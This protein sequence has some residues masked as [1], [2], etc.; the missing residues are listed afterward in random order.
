M[1]ISVLTIFQEEKRDVDPDVVKYSLCFPLDM[2]DRKTFCID[3]RWYE[4]ECICPLDISLPRKVPD[5]SI[6]I[7]GLNGSYESPVVNAKFVMI[8]GG[9]YYLFYVHRYFGL[10]DGLVCSVLDKRKRRFISSAFASSWLA[11]FQGDDS[12]RCQ[13]S[14]YKGSA[15][16]RQVYIVGARLARD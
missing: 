7:P 3:H 10:E 2:G 6:R 4:M 1:C 14:S 16:P 15:L 11:A 9:E 5:C 12:W 13:D 8:Y